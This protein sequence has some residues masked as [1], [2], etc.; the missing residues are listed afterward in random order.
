MVNLKHVSTTWDFVMARKHSTYAVQ[1]PDSCAC[2][3]IPLYILLLCYTYESDLYD[4]IKIK[5]NTR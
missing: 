4:F 5:L 1:K 3:G 2:T